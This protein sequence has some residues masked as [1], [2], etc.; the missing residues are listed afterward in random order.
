MDIHVQ[1]SLQKVG[2]ML[3]T[4]L[5]IGNMSLVEVASILFLVT[6][7]LNVHICNSCAILSLTFNQYSLG[8]Y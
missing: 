4:L 3:L 5:E 7:G 8:P 1:K 6:I 2:W